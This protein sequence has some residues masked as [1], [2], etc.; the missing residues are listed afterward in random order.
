M[1]KNNNM[2]VVSKM[3]G[4]TLKNNKKR[5]FVMFL[6]VAL[7]SFMVFS[8]LTVGITYFQMQQIQNMRLSG[9]RFDAIMYG[10]TKEQIELCENDPDVSC[11]G[12][13]AVA[14]Y[15]VE[16]EMDQTPN[17]GMMWA[18]NNY[19]D[20]MMAPVRENVKGTYPVEEN[21]VMV[22]ETAL[23]ECGL[24]GLDVGDTF[25]MTYGTM[26]SETE[27]TFQIS[28]IWEGFGPQKI[29]YMSEA[30]YQQ[31]GYEVADVVS[32]RYYINFEHSFMTKA[33][34]EAFIEKMNLGKQ[35]NLFFESDFGNSVQILAGVIGIVLAACLCAYLLIYNI[36]YLSVA[37]N[38]RHYGLLQTIGM[39]EKQIYRFMWTQ[40]IRIGISG[41]AAGM[42]FGAF[43][44]LFLLPEVVQTLGIKHVQVSIS[45]HPLI[46]LAT[47]LFILL[48]VFSA[49]WRP[50]KMAVS[51][52]P[53]EAVRY[54]P[55]HG[56]RRTHK[57]GKGN[58]LWRMAREQ[59]WKNKKKSIMVIFSLAVS[60][61]V[62]LCMVTLLESQ[63]AREIVSN[64]MDTDLVIVNDTIA[65]EEREDRGRAFGHELL[66]Q[67]KEQPGV[68][69]IHTVSFLEVMV[70]WEPDFA[71]MWMEEFYAMW[72][73]VP[74]EDDIEEYKAH[75]EN[76]TTSLI[77][78]DK[79]E[80][81][82]LNETLETPVD[83]EAFLSGRICILYRNN[84][85][86]TQEDITGKTVTCAPYGDASNRKTF[87]IGAL[88]DEYYYTA[89]L[90]S[91]P[92]IIVSNEA[93][94]AFAEESFVVKSSIRYEKEYDEETEKAL[95]T[96][97]ERQ[98]E[99]KDISYESKIEEMKSVQEAQG[100]MWLVG[101]GIVLILAVIG[102]MNYV[103]TYAGNI[104]S[105]E[106]ELAVMESIGMSEGQIVRMLVLEGAFYSIGAWC[107]TM[108]LG[109]GITYC[110][111]QS[112][113]YMNV[114]FEVPV[115]PIL[116]AA[117]CILLLCI[118]VPVLLY[119]Q[120]GRQG[121]ITQ[122]LKNID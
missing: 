99:R 36:M 57:T 117:V 6:A 120:I 56:S 107:V 30:F 92:T 68:S 71:D 110:L 45:F 100:N 101:Y 3:A 14:G 82:Y 108:T 73:S 93:M 98:P 25:T 28:G 76:F 48:T 115:I 112:M 39:T 66:N 121:S 113:N 38:V 10:A 88:T 53:I 24:E 106:K 58:I 65:K 11:T 61:S 37:G 51:I 80:F 59:V 114:P 52:S 23:K 111:Y 96:L 31:T 29:F 40:M 97:I 105:R 46:F 55:G 22:T 9:A 47:V 104:Q 109:M 8:V 102:L 18:D 32:G 86:F 15:V 12:I 118:F 62:F 87:E 83:E 79:E 95:L 26:E 64:Y 94:K 78:I 60:L 21:E 75:P 69:E 27:D 103:N 84:L 4:K 19:W 50:A 44:S 91:T 49:Y 17:V 70:P 2:A 77:G 67:I 85:D 74:Y 20:I 7:A 13:C 90:G 5:S 122:R 42:A 116:S 35:Q 72:M 54:R 33:E 119:K 63:A 16:T 43:V 41:I 34:Q 89:V 1:L 81:G